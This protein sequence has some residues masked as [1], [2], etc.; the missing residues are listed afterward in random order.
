MQT[1]TRGNVMRSTIRCPVAGQGLR[2]ALSG[3]SLVVLFTACGDGDRPVAPTSTVRD[4]PGASFT[5][6]TNS[7]IP[8]ARN[9]FWH[10]IDLKRETDDW[11]LE[12]KIS[13]NADVAVSRVLFPAG[14]HSGWHTH[15]GPVIAEVITG[16]VSFYLGNDPTCTP[17]VRTAGQTYI[18][19]GDIPHIAR[20][21]TDEPAENLA[22]YFAPP[23]V[24]LRHDEPSPGN[25]PF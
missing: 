24:P 2:I 6:A 16:T 10:P 4:Q 7:S 12:M 20:N 9:T 17:I 21:E 15:P 8:L 1:T 3:L 18:E 5:T 13:P 23:G 22:I 19:A 25:C 14:T 11:G